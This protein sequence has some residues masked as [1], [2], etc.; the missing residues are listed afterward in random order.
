[1]TLMRRMSGA[2]PINRLRDEMDR[3]FGGLLGDG[4]A[5][6]SLFTPPGV[7]AFPALNV[8]ETDDNLF[9]EAEL[10]G[11]KM[12]D[13]EVFVEGGE[14]TLRGQRKPAEDERATFH[15]RE[16]G[17]G[18]FSRVLRL[19]IDIDVE[20][21]EAN[22]QNGVLTIRL[23]KAPSARPRKIEIRSAG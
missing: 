1:M 12:E 15:R 3:L 14:L 21:V 8:W 2:R 17:V 11:S 13:I 23:P 7:R 9:V 19:P 18:S 5:F 20:R 4:P 16:R 10:P 22:L 6:E